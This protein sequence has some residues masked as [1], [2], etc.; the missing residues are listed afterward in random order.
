VQ[1]QYEES[2]CWD[3]YDE[4]VHTLVSAEVEE[5][6]SYQREAVWLQTDRGWDWQYENDDER[7]PYPVLNDDIADYMIQ[8]HVYA[9]AGRWTNPRI[10]V[11][12]DSR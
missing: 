12:L 2:V 10:G 6:P 3:V 7:D 8:Q 1:V 4:V 5:L 11:F 9:A